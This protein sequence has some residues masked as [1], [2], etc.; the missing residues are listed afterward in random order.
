MKQKKEASAEAPQPKLTAISFGLHKGLDNWQLVKI[1][2]DPLTL[3]TAKA[4]VIYQDP[5][6]DVVM[7]RFMIEASV[8]Q[9]VD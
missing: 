2:Y 8:F 3:V 1:Q 6:R 4:E 9:E 5:Y 7:E